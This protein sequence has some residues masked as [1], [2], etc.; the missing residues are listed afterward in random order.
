S[1]PPVKRGQGR[2]WAWGCKANPGLQAAVGLF[3]SHPLRVEAQGDPSCRA[4]AVSLNQDL[5]F[6]GA[7]RRPEHHD[8]V[9]VLLPTCMVV[10]G[11]CFA[12]HQDGD[13]KVLGNFGQELRCAC[14]ASK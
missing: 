5:Y 3:E 1:W 4:E 7:A 2:Y 10:G 9:R 6:A 8:P 13:T 11:R 14:G 12:Q